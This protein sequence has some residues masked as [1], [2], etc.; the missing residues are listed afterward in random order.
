MGIGKTP[1]EYL[2]NRKRVAVS[3]PTIKGAS[4]IEF[5]YTQGTRERW[6]TRCPRC[7]EYHEVRFD[8]IQF[9]AKPKRIA[10]KESWYVDVTG[11]KCPGCGEVSEEQEVKNQI[12]AGKRRIPMPFGITVAGHSGSEA[13]LHLGARGKISSR[14]LQGKERSGTAQSVEEY[15]CG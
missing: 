5:L 4:Q 8:D 12:P 3:T 7:G 2:Y 14:I 10:G 1:S 15:R 13:L 11:W 6:K 9:K